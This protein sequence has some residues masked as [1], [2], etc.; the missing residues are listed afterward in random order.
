ME[1]RKKLKVAL[2]L[3]EIISPARAGG[4]ER[5]AFT[6]IREGVEIKICYLRKETK[7][8]DTEKTVDVAKYIRIAT[9]SP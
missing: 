3:G 6:P 4:G 2:V 7:D 1:K 9:V 8:E 5:V